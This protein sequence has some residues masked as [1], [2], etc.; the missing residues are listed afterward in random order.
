MAYILS[1]ARPPKDIKHKVDLASGRIMVAFREAPGYHMTPETDPAKALA[2]ARRN[3]DSLLSDPDTPLLFQRLAPGFFDADG[4]WYKDRLEKGRPMTA[5]SLKIRQSHI[6]NYILP[7]LGEY[8]IRTVSGEAI[9]VAIRDA[10]RYTLREGSATETA[11]KPLTRSTRSKLLYTLKL[12]YDRW[13][14]LGYVDHN[15]T[16]GIIKYTKE[17]ERPRGILPADAIGRLF[18][19]THGELVRVWGSSMWAALML[20]LYDT[21]ARAGE[22][23]ALRWG[24]YYPDRGY[25][26][27]TKAIEGG[28]SATVKGT[29]NSLSKPAYLQDRTVQELAIWRAESRFNGDADY[30]FTVTGD[31]PVSNAAIG[32][33]FARTL[34]R[35]GYDSTGWTPYWL[36]HTFVTRNL[37]VLT[38]AEVSMLAGHSVQVSRSNYQH[39]DDETMYEQSSGAREK[40]R[41]REKG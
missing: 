21:G 25:L 31:A 10:Q 20:V 32:Q 4:A 17:P 28:T 6:V 7:L 13:I 5:A 30:M 12:M 3:K 35:L 8:D 27:L 38:E 37:R 36:R 39:R 15:P 40:L 14:M 34:A 16:A 29:K 22:P 24:D 18:P 2:W 19:E 41:K 9:N 11:R 26:P 1:M 23:R 33:A